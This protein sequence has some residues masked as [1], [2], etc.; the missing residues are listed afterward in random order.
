MKRERAV[1]GCKKGK[2]R[3]L[4]SC[5]VDTLSPFNICP[6]PGTNTIKRFPDPS[7]ARSKKPTQI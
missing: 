4:Q 3:F 5:K 1:D 6:Q 2:G 7:V